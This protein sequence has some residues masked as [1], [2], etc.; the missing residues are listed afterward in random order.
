MNGFICY[1]YSGVETMVG[2]FTKKKQMALELPPPPSPPNAAPLGDIPPIQPKPAEEQEALPELPE[3]LAHEEIELPEAPTPEIPEIPPPEDHHEETLL[4]VPEEKPV[5]PQLEEVPAVFDQTI[6]PQEIVR[7][8]VGP[9]FVSLD[10]Y[11]TIMEHSNRV[12][13]KLMES[14]DFLKH[15]NEIKVEEEKTFAK[16]QS[17]LEDIERKLGHVDRIIA[18]A[19]R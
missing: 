11:R 3:I 14:E 1:H 19:Q 12:R 17:Q 18:K 4:P 9:M 10:D 7:K 13:A 2:F 16:W 5:V 15:L 6:E 8:P